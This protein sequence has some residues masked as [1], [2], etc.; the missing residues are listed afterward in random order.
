MGHHAG[1]HVL[2]HVAMIHPEAA[3]VGHHVGGNHLCRPYI[4]DVS[5]LAP[6]TSADFTAGRRRVDES[7]R[8][9]LHRE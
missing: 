1:G 2:A 3:F 6:V 4:D 8:A 5:G 9:Q 7:P